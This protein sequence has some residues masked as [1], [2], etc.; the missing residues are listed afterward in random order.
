MKINRCSR[1]L[2]MKPFKGV[3]GRRCKRKSKCTKVEVKQE[4]VIKEELNDGDDDINIPRPTVD[5]RYLA[6]Y[7]GP[8]DFADDFDQIKDEVKCEEEETGREKESAPCERLDDSAAANDD[9]NEEPI[10]DA[11]DVKPTKPVGRGKKR[12]KASKNQ[13]KRTIP[14][15][16]AAKK[17]KKS[18]CHVCNH[19]ASNNSNL[20]IMNLKVSVFLLHFSTILAPIGHNAAKLFIVAASDIEPT[21]FVASHNEFDRL[22]STSILYGV[23]DI[24]SNRPQATH[25]C[26]REL[27]QIYDGIHRKEIWAIKALDSSAMPVPGFVLG[28]NFWMGSIQGCH[29]VQNPPPLTISNRFKRFAHS[30]L[31]SATA[32]FDIDYRM[33]Y[34]EHRSPFQVQVEFLLETNKILHVGLCL[35]RSCSNGEIANLTQEFFDSSILS[36]QIM[37][38]HQPNVLQVKDLNAKTNL[39]DKWSFRL[40]GFCVGFSLLMMVIGYMREG[41]AYDEA[42]KTEN[43]IE[44][45]NVSSGLVKNSPSTPPDCPK[46]SAPKNL[47]LDEIVECFSLRKNIQML[48]NF[49]T[50]ANAVPIVDGLK[51]I[52]CFSAVILH[53]YWY[54]HFTVHNA[55]MMFSYGEQ[56]LWQWVM[57]ASTIIDVFFT[58]SGLLLTY[59]FLLNQSKLN[60]IKNNNLLQNLKLFGKQMLNRYIRLTPMYLIVIGCVE[61]ITLRLVETSPFWIHDRNDVNCSEFWWR[62]LLYIQNFFSLE[63]MGVNWSWYLACEMQFTILSTAL[64]FIYAKYPNAAKL[65]FCSLF[66]ICVGLLFSVSIFI[67]FTLSY[68]VLHSLLS[69]IYIRPWTRVLP[70]L[71]GVAAGYVMYMMKGK[72]PL[73]EKTIK[74]TWIVMITIPILCHKSTIN[75]NTSYVTTAFALTIMRILYPASISW[76]ILASHAGY[77]GRFAKFLNHPIFVHINKLSYGIYLLNPVVIILVYGWQDHSTHIDPVSMVVMTTG[78]N[79][80]I[81]LASVVFSLLFEIPYT[82]LSAIILRQSSLKRKMVACPSKPTELIGAKKML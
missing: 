10:G 81:Y 38:D 57:T 16:Q 6:N 44:T 11:I 27:K 69:D 18:K 25:Q 41:S 3:S 82:K 14:R 78:I 8:I 70:Y 60:E 33:V 49:E 56:P 23:V 54:N 5:G 50:P 47:F 66:A 77:G 51:S 46:I 62:N 58:I 79:V 68:D 65:M 34:A 73:G 4:P 40:I 55:A 45:R 32:P 61:I 30:D 9:D 35:P 74:I 15:N 1:K 24:A 67:K 71:V 13:S 2:E 36:A 75:P 64:L 22:K 39:M 43:P 72:L 19:L 37:H 21:E 53:V 26:H 28:H 31:W 76:M 52:A 20:K 12:N 59:N 7:E 42:A 48:T 29:A 80:Y 17:Q 63:K